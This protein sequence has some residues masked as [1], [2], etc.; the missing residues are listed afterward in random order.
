MQICVV[1]GI[2]V[3]QDEQSGAYDWQSIIVNLTSRMDAIARKTYKNNPILAEELSAQAFKK[4]SAPEYKEKTFSKYRQKSSPESFVLS[5]FKRV[6]VDVHRKKFGYKR[7]PVWVEKLGVVWKEVWS[8][9][10]LKRRDP[11]DIISKFSKVEHRSPDDNIRPLEEELTFSAEEIKNMIS[12][13]RIKVVDCGAQTG[14][15]NH[16]FSS[17]DPVTN[18]GVKVN[19][20]ADNFERKTYHEVIEALTM[21]FSQIEEQSLG[22]VRD[23]LQSKESV[24]AIDD[25]VNRTCKLKLD[26]SGEDRLLL[27]IVFLDGKKVPFAAKMLQKPEHQIRKALK[28]TLSNLQMQF[29]EAG[30]SIDVLRDVLS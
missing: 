28:N 10:C 9:L 23:K 29:Q 19:S 27:K 13:I 3:H 4:M 12:V 22:D 8:L 11:E 17:G 18:G 15:M 21:F 16:D 7:P 6:L 30:I 2:M 26:M 1:G 25:V 24:M 20:T 14:E 5:C